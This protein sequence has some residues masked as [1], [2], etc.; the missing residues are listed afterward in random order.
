[1]DG[2]GNEGAAKPG[3]ERDGEP[4]DGGG[5]PAVAGREGEGY[6]HDDGCRRQWLNGEERQPIGAADKADA[7]GD[8]GHYPTG[9]AELG[10]DEEEAEG[11]QEERSIGIE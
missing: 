5:Q 3:E 9:E 4:A 2:A 6:G 10:A 11:R 8:P 1:M 7:A